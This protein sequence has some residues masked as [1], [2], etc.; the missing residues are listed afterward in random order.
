MVP[1]N[2]RRS[3]VAWQLFRVVAVLVWLV[4]VLQACGRARLQKKA[5]RR[6]FATNC[7]FADEYCIAKCQRAGPGP[8]W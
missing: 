5:T 7:M 6:W 4:C 1:T 8:R 3:T 2:K